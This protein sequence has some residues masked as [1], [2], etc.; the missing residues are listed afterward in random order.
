MVCS[1]GSVTGADPTAAVESTGSPAQETG[2]PNTRA[3]SDSNSERRMVFLIFPTLSGTEFCFHNN[4]LFPCCQAEIRISLS[5]AQTASL[6]H[7]PS[8]F[9]VRQRMRTAAL[10]GVSLPVYPTVRHPIR[11]P[12]R[13]AHPV[14]GKPKKLPAPGIIPDAGSTVCRTVL[15]GKELRKISRP[16]RT[17]QYLAPGISGRTGRSRSAE[18]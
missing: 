8:I 1:A 17:V 6:S 4:R 10:N 3:N 18:R 12:H 5:A 7:V 11:V 14:S 9:P 16:D 13:S 15:H 2:I